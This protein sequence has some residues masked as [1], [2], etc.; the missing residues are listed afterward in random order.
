MLYDAGG[1]NRNIFGHQLLQDGT[2]RTDKLDLWG[3]RQNQKLQ[4]DKSTGHLHIVLV[5]TSEET[6]CCSHVQLLSQHRKL[7]LKKKML[8][9]L[10]LGIK[11]ETFLS[12]VWHSTTELSLPPDTS[13]RYRQYISNSWHY[14][15]YIKVTQGEVITTVTQLFLNILLWKQASIVKFRGKP[16]QLILQVITPLL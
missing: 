8:P 4:K 11:P 1:R 15:Q 2:D 6:L 5:S 9:L 10:L 7:T 12:Q 13:R 16:E 3:K 14:R